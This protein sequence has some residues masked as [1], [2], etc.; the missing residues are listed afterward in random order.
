[1]TSI[2]V[3]SLVALITTALALIHE[4][5]LRCAAHSVG[6]RELI[7]ALATTARHTIRRG[8][9]SSD[10]RQ[11]DRATLQ[12]KLSSSRKA[13]ARLILILARGPGSPRS[14]AAASW[15]QRSSP[16]SRGRRSIGSSLEPVS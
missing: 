5:R 8:T 16:W 12:P 6:R 3:L 9:G 10:G 13:L 4:S 11:A 7:P 1:M 15:S 14:S 2:T